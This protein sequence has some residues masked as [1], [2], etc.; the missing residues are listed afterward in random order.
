VSQ[1]IEDFWAGVDAE[2]A[3][4][5][6]VPELEHLPLRSTDTAAV[7]ALRLTSLGPYRIF[8]YYSRPVGSG[9]FPGLLQM[10]RYG[11]VN[12]VPDY[13]DR[14]RYAVLQVVH[15]GQRLANQPF[16]AAYPGLLTLG[17][18]SPATYIYRGIVADCLRGAE[19][20]VS[21]PEVDASRIGIQGD[22][23]ALITAAR[24]PVFAALQASE[25]ML[26]RLLEAS[27]R[28]TAYPVEEVSDYLRHR[29]ALREPVE[30]TLAYFDPVEHVGRVR[31]ASLLLAND[32][33][34]LG[35]TRWLR[36]LREAFGGPV[37]EYRVTH[38]G[39][40]DH[41]WVDAWLARHLGV[42]PRARFRKVVQ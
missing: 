28:T 24:W 27:Q 36:P 41:D 14:E 5:P 40:T 2:L 8:G 26:Y 35:G 37:E 38:N 18:E 23:L 30:R 32:D 16:D 17:I 15:R 29:S 12:N 31:A 7:Y 19:F 1:A 13:H 11:S 25:L 10:P 39:A 4:Y 42:E 6:P 3:A 22:D 20:L 21:R 9:P 33:D 34:A